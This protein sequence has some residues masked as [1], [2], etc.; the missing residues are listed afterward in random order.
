MKVV[1]EKEGLVV[2]EI[3]GKEIELNREEFLRVKTQIEMGDV[4]DF[5]DRKGKE[6]VI[7][8]KGDKLILYEV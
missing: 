1:K 2:I 4:V 7:Q 5:S 3:E 6:Y 8:R